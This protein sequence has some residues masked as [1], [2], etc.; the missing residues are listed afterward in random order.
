MLARAVDELP[1]G[2]HWRYEPKW[3]GFRCIAARDLRTSLSARSGGRLD[4]RFAELHDAVRL[5]IPPDTAL[6]GE[7]VRW[8][9]ERLD[10]D[11]L[12]RRNAA[13]TRRAKRLAQEEPC[14]LV[15]F[16]LLREKGTDLTRRPLSYRRGRL[17]ELFAWLVEPRLMLGWQTRD[18]GEA[19]RWYEEMAGVGVEGLIV[20]D[21]R[22]TYR[23]GRRDWL[24]FKR[25]VTTEAIVG[26]AVTRP[27][28]PRM[29]VLGR[30]DDAGEL[31]IAG[32]TVELTREQRDEIAPR[33]RGA[34]DD[35]PWPS[36]LASSWGTR[37]RL[38]YRRVEPTVVV[39]IQPDA[40]I[41]GT[42]WRN[43]VR[44]TRVRPDLTPGDVPLGLDLEKDSG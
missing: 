42:R 20:K 43:P 9:G 2:E 36:T 10:F 34:G 15:V 12:L 28:D 33:L 44:L 18:S 40:S 29:L 24:K 31:R 11:A 19:M 30:Y 25:R 21:E 26:G 27:D 6:D 23:A 3:D 8:S 7:I 35:H 22:R 32:Q 38:E 16:D 37:E 5:A 13:D 14:H 1:V 4:G 39:E 41:T 17:E